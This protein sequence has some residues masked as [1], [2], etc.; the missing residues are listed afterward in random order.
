VAAGRTESGPQGRTVEAGTIYDLASL[1]KILST[2]ILTMIFWERRRIELLA[3]LEQF[4]LFRVPEDKARLTPAQ[5]LSHS[6]GLPAWRPFYQDLAGL[7]V[8][9]RRPAVARAILAEPLAFS[10]GQRAVYSDL[11]F[12]LLGFILEAIGDKRQDDLFEAWITRPLGVSGLSY[13]PLDLPEKGIPDGIA[14]TED[15]PCRGGVIRGVVHDDNALFLGGVA[16]HAGLFG[17]ADAV[18]RIFCSLR[19]AYRGMDGGLVSENTVRSFWTRTYS[20]PG[21]SWAL[22]FDGP[23]G[24]QP[25]AGR[26]FSAR[27]VGHLGY[28]GTSLWYDPDRDLTIILLSNRVHPTAGNLGIRSFR[29]RI[30]EVAVEAV[31]EHEKLRPLERGRPYSP[32]QSSGTE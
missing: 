4:R 29:P 6:T 22:G 13:R 20:A 24:V 9:Q 27:S 11:N 25:S 19:R 12:M 2:T 30:H 3:P 10:P 18:W 17:T 14:P 1:T 28:T 32:G 23:S 31:D 16:G 7:P 21:S 15:L 5:L 26:Y 8:E